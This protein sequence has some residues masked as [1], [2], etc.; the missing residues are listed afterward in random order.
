MELWA[1][2]ALKNTIRDGGSTSLKTLCTAYTAS[3]APTVYAFL[4]LLIKKG[5]VPVR[6]SARST[7]HLSNFTWKYEKLRKQLS[8]N[9]TVCQFLHC[10]SNCRETLYVPIGKI[11]IWLNFFTTCGCDGC[12]KYDVMK[13]FF[14]S[15][16]NISQNNHHCHRLIC[17]CTVLR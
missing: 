5:I 12:D 4:Q 6:H 16:R 10:V 17:S 9:K 2:G 7:L 3:T 1:F 8:R 13:N 14:L 11:Y 15:N